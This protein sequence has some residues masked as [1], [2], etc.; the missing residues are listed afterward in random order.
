[1]EQFHVQI[2]VKDFTTN[3]RDRLPVTKF[4]MMD[5]IVWVVRIVHN[6]MTVLLAKFVNKA[7]IVTMEELS[8]AQSV[9]T[10][11]ELANQLA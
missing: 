5:S 1:M 7:T 9:L 3:L 8:N 6:L 4:V 2:V 10:R 11:I